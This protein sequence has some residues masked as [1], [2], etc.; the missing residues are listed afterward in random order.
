VKGFTQ[1]R[2]PMLVWSPFKPDVYGSEQPGQ[3]SGPGL[4]GGLVSQLPQT[5]SCNAKN[6]CF[7]HD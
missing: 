5:L 6:V 3:S 1:A 7:I 2:E 4:Q